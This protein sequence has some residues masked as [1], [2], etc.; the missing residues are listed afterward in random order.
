MIL[1]AEDNEINRIVME[2]IL[3]SQNYQFKIVENGRK[4][5]EEY[6]SSIPALI[7][8]DVSM[9]EMNGYEATKMIRLIEQSTGDHIPIIG[10]TAHALTGDREKCI[11]AG[12]DDYISKPISPSVLKEKIQQ[13]ISGKTGTNCLTG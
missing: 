10:A 13:W 9:P 7:L 11:E 12:M 5:V 6:K 3:L 2:Q 4:A 8:M 1:V